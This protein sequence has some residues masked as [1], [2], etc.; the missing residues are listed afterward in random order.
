MHK[1]FGKLC[2]NTKI[3]V[4]DPKDSAKTVFGPIMLPRVKQEAAKKKEKPSFAETLKKNQEKEL[5]KEQERKEKA[6][7]VAEQERIAAIMNKN[8][9]VAV[10][11]KKTA[12]S[13]L[14]R[15][16]SVTRQQVKPS[17]SDEDDD[18]EEESD[19][20]DELGDLVSEAAPFLAAGVAMAGAV[21]G[22]GYTLFKYKHR[23]TK[24]GQ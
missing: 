9:K 1:D 13:N 20:E 10:S 11:S 18:D 16:T 4:P 14:G 23:L 3:R 17:K 8:K 7:Q 22:V 21:L 15:T 5:K 2:Q 19:E 6:K 24:G 12:P